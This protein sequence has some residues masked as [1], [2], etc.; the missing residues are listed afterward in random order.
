MGREARR[1]GVMRW[2]LRLPWGVL[3]HDARTIRSIE[4]VLPWLQAATA[5]LL[6]LLPPSPPSFF[7]LLQN[8]RLQAAI[9]PLSTTLARQAC[10]LL[11]PRLALVISK[12]SARTGMRC[13]CLRHCPKKQRTLRQQGRRCCRLRGQAG[14]LL[15]NCCSAGNRENGAGGVV[16]RRTGHLLA[17]AVLRPLVLLCQRPSSFYAA[18]PSA[19]SR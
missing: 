9:T 3:V 16:V 11:L 2:G 18:K 15:V 8:S 12:V 13:C 17:L 10:S 19:S 14:W 5:L 6:L 4:G 7:R 1:Q